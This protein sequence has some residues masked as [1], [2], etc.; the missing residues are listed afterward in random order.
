MLLTSAVTLSLM[1]VSLLS[2]VGEVNTVTA[3]TMV[4][5]TLFGCLSGHAPRTAGVGIL[6]VLL[7]TSMAVGAHTGLLTFVL[8]LPVGVLALRG[9]TLQALALAA[10]GTAI[11]TLIGSWVAGS[12]EEVLAN[13]L[14]W[15]LLTGLSLVIGLLGDRARSHSRQ[16]AA[17]F[18][19]TRADERRLIASELHDSVARLAT[20]I[21]VQA[22]SAH[23]THSDDPE[24]AEVMRSISDQCRTLTVETRQILCVLRGCSEDGAD[25]LTALDFGGGQRWRS[26]EECLRTETALLHKIGYEV[27][28][29]GS[30]PLGL[31]R[32]RRDLL[33][34]AI[35]EA[36]TNVRRHGDPGVPVRVMLDTEAH[37]AEFVVINGVPV[38][39][40]ATEST[41]LGLESLYRGADAAGASL[42][43]A[44]SGDAWVLR[45]VI[46]P[47]TRLL[48]PETR[49]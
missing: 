34:R 6:L 49:S 9:E 2:S 28:V 35:T 26:P 44:R 37:E 21:A 39:P 20:A 27:V 15:G 4:L 24:L 17:D 18:W 23:L 32:V 10:G 1:F 3:L 47:A 45:L 25:L 11:V 16:L 22:E 13:L 5:L 38:V 7:S 42:T 29:D 14:L 40:R 30:I 48:Q 46:P 33:S 41:G 31:D 19:R 8:L 36:L 43:A 12:S